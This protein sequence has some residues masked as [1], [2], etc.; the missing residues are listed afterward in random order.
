MEPLDPRVRI[1]WLVG[2]LVIAAVLG[3]IVAAADYYLFGIG[4]WIAGVA[5]AFAVVLGGAYVWLRYR[6]WAFEV[7]D[8]DL[9]IRRGVLTRVNSVVPYVRVQHVDTQ[10]GPVERAVG[11]SS[12]VVYTAGSRGADITIPGLA[13]ER[14]DDLRERLRSLAIDSESE[15][16]V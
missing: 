3:A 13:P 9:Y 7:N 4:S 11:L 12:V 5:V 6:V 10:R 14:A 2:M 15:D 16:A 8:E 1:V